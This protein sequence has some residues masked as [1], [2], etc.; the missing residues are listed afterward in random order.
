M[1]R[2]IL[3]DQCNPFILISKS[4]LSKI[5]EFFIIR[6]YLSHYSYAA[7]RLLMNMYTKRYK[8]KRFVEPGVFLLA[9]DSKDDIPRLGVYINVIKSI[10]RDMEG[11][12]LES[13]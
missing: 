1:S 2:Q 4:D 3:I 12:S 13:E 8:M 11:F 10:A 7:K 5:D 6:N 9:R